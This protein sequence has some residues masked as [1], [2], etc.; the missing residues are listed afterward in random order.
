VI[1]FVRLEALA[2]WFVLLIL[3][4]VLGTGMC[5]PLTA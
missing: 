1:L 3:S 2:R 5:L 4:A